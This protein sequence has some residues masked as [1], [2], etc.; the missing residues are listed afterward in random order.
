MTCMSD[1]IKLELTKLFLKT[2]SFLFSPQRRLCFIPFEVNKPFKNGYKID[3]VLNLVFT[4]YF[5]PLFF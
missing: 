4:C 2:H 1:S 5:V 3:N